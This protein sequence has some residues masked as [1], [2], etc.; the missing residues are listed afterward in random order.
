MKKQLIGAGVTAITLT[1]A[2]FAYQSPQ[3]D[4]APASHVTTAVIK[5]EPVHP[6]PTPH[7]TPNPEHPATP[8]PPVVHPTPQPTTHPT[9]PPKPQSGSV[10]PDGHT[11]YV[12][13]TVV[14]DVPVVM[15]TPYPHKT[16][17]P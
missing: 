15:S 4:T 5:D 11:I 6:E 2:A 12:D 16:P 9:P 3:N 13:D 1:G 7:E 17:K 14:P 8:T 10:N